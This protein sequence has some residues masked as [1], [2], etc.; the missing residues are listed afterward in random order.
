MTSVLILA[1]NILNYYSELEQKKMEQN[2]FLKYKYYVNTEFDSNV[3]D[4]ESLSNGNRLVFKSCLPAKDVYLLMKL[5]HAIYEDNY[6]MFEE[7]SSD[8]EAYINEYYEKSEK[9]ENNNY[10]DNIQIYNSVPCLNWDFIQL[11]DFEGINWD[12]DE[13]N[14][15]DFQQ[16]FEIKDLL[17]LLNGEYNKTFDINVKI[18]YGF[19]SEESESETETETELANEDKENVI[20]N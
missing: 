20:S 6:W 4:F 1:Q 7:Y 3:T 16:I 10:I 14:Q 19:S 11:E 5:F 8:A 2:P 17:K 15:E 18:Y 9:E 13:Y 12:T